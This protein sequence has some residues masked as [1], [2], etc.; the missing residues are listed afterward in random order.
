MNAPINSGAQ[1]YCHVTLYTCPDDGSLVSRLGHRLAYG[2]LPGCWR[3]KPEDFPPQAA[4]VAPPK[5]MPAPVKADLLLDA[6]GCDRDERYAGVHLLDVDEDGEAKTTAERVRGGW[7][8]ADWE[9]T[10][11]LNGALAGTR[12]W[13]CRSFHTVPDL[14][15]QRLIDH[16]R[17]GDTPY[18]VCCSREECGGECGNEWR[19][20]TTPNAQRAEA[21][22]ALLTDLLTEDDLPD[23]VRERIYTLIAGSY[24]DDLP[25]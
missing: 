13:F 1:P 8:I 14:H 23:S 18:T 19:G 15:L 12:Y 20:T 9:L 2:G 17:A 24:T 7:R 3:V 6:P 16:A 22:E 21:A 5:D 11:E 25:F 10:E 4:V